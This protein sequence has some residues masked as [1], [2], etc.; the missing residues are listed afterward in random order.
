MKNVLCPQCGKKADVMMLICKFKACTECTKINT[1]EQA[2]K[3]QSKK[4]RSKI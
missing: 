2:E 4:I 1:R 3:I